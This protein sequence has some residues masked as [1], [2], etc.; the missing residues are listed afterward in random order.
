MNWLDRTI[1]FV[2]PATAL[3]RARH[4]AAIAMLAR[5]YEGARVGRRTEGWVVAGT[6]ANAEIGTALSRLRDRSRDLVRNNPYAAKAVQ[7]VVSNL[8]GTGILPRARSAH[9]GVNDQADRLWARFAESCD[10][11]GLTDFSGLQ[12]LIVRAMAESGECLVRIR[13]RRIEDGL[14]VPLQLQLLEPD[15]LDAGKTGDL[16]NGGFVVQGV[17]F[18]ALGRRRAY[19]LYPVHPGE[20]AMF[21]RATLA[22]QPIPASSVLHLF[23]HLRPGQ[24]R[25]V[26]WF[27]PVILKLRDLDEY[28]DAELLRKKIEACFAAFVTGSDDEETLGPTPMAAG[29]RA[30]SPA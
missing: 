22:S 2:A 6:S 1:G 21:R 5:N 9:A 24:V 29:S 14:P 10:A 13:D 4:R 15:H 23:D 27:A 17:E 30:S 7:A 28:D 11:D 26:P 12:A 16:A 25:G 20:V 19:W 18:D 8:V 3:S